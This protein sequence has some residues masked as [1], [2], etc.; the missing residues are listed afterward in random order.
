VS[1][2][3]KALTAVIKAKTAIETGRETVIAHL[4]VTAGLEGFSIVLPSTHTARK[5]EEK[6]QVGLANQL[7]RN[8]GVL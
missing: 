3:A 2:L 5:R 6:Y 7:E 8:Q 1:K 4:L